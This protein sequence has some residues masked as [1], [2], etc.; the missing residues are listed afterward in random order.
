MKSEVSNSKTFLAN[1]KEPFIVYSLFVSGL[2]N[3]SQ[4]LASLKV[5]VLL[6]I[7]FGE[8]MVFHLLVRYGFW[9][10]HIIGSCT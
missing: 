9:L 6:R 5:G 2:L 4:N 10:L 1:E 7:K 8:M 3:W